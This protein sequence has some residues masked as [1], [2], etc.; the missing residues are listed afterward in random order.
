MNKRN[1]RKIMKDFPG[2]Y[3]KHNPLYSSGI[4]LPMTFDCDDGWF[5]LLYQISKDIQRVIDNQPDELLKDFAVLQVKE[6]FGELRFYVGS[7]NQEIGDLIKKAE[8]MSG[9]LCEIC[10]KKGSMSVKGGWYKTVCPYHRKTEG[11]REIK[12]WRK[13]K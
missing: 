3:P 1:S 10:G 2:L 13:T 8:E 4:I 5:K 9:Q 12:S 6:K 7:F 11:Y